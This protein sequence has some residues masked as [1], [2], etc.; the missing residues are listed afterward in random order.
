MMINLKNIY[1]IQIQILINLNNIIS[2][3][4]KILVIYR[5]FKINGLLMLK[6][7]NKLFNKKKYLNNI[8][9]GLY[10]IE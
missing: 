1:K 5:V 4:Q 8:V 7:I 3:I 9:N 2:K 6:I 10:K